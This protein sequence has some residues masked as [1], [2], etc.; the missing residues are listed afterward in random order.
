MLGLGLG[1]GLELGLGLGL[2]LGLGLGG[3]CDASGARG[4]N[5]PRGRLLYPNIVGGETHIVLV[6]Y[7]QIFEA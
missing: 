2:R 6:M 3:P 7:V 5:P 1:L 4:W